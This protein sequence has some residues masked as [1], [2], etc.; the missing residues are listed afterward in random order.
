MGAC[1]DDA[2]DDD[3]D[4]DNDNDDDDD[5]AAA[6]RYGRYNTCRRLLELSQGPNIIN[7]TDADGLTGLH[8]AAQNGHTKIISLLLQKGAVVQR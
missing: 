3:D 5:A 1:Y 6:D 4:N 8:I 7:E 2:D